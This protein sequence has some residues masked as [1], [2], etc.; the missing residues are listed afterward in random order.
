M[1]RGLLVLLAQL[2]K[3]DEEVAA[4]SGEWSGNDIVC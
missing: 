2:Y 4:A 3:K 1:L